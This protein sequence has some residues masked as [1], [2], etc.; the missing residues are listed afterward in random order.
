MS[1]EPDCP[2]TYLDVLY[3]DRNQKGRHLVRENIS[4]RQEVIRI[5]HIHTRSDAVYDSFMS[6]NAN[7][8]VNTGK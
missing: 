7:V 3:N 6:R 2:G 4:R 1:N 8:R 5:V